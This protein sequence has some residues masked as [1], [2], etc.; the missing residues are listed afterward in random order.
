[1]RGWEETAGERGVQAARPYGGW[2]DR[3]MRASVVCLN[4]PYHMLSAPLL[5]W[6]G[7]WKRAL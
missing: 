6:E 4:G 5:D 3:S 2:I 7:M 1:M